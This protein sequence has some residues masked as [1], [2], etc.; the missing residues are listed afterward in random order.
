MGGRER[1]GEMGVVVGGGGKR[2][3]GRGRKDIGG[4]INVFGCFYRL[5]VKY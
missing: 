3:E 4:R 5:F 1:R 2:S